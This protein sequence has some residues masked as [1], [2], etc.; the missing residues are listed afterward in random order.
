MT[1]FTKTLQFFFFCNSLFKYDLNIS[2]LNQEF[3]IPEKPGND[4]SPHFISLTLRDTHNKSD[5]AKCLE[6]IF[7]YYLIGFIIILEIQVEATS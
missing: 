6:Q 3:D 4:A 2:N 5:S 1:A 7:Q